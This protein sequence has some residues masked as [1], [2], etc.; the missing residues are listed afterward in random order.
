MGIAAALDALPLDAVGR[1]LSEVGFHHVDHLIGCV[2]LLRIRF[3][4]WVKHVMADVAFQ[5]LSH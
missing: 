5:E 2:C 1:I 3:S 4:L